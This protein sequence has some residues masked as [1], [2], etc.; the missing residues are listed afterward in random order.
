MKFTRFLSVALLALGV[1]VQADA[2]TVNYS[3]AVVN[4][5]PTSIGQEGV[6]T[7]NPISAFVP[8]LVSDISGVL[9]SN[10]MIEFTYKPTSGFVASGL[11]GVLGGFTNESGNGFASQ[12]VSFPGTSV[13]TPLSTSSYIFA[14]AQYDNTTGIVTTIIKNYSAGLASF[15]SLWGALV[16]GSTVM[17]VSYK[18]SAVPLPAALPLFAFGL[19]GLAGVGY[20][21]R[22]NKAA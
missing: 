5:S 14:T 11:A 4:M 2:A 6:V 3:G 22:K 15:S 13:Q 8:L 9:P 12:V 17:Q 7:V 19:A 10:S 21:N 20:R 18:I 16:S 1:S